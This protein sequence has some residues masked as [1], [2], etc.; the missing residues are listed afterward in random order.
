MSKLFYT[1]DKRLSSPV[2]SKQLPAC[3]TAEEKLMGAGATFFIARWET[4]YKEGANC[5][6]LIQGQNS[7]TD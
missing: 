4:K 5:F 2:C 7:L 6:I 1:L 3:G